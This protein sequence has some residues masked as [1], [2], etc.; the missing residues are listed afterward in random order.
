[1]R[2]ITCIPARRR[3]NSEMVRLGYVIGV[4][5]V[6]ADQLTKRW[7]EAV[8]DYARAVE[9]MP[10]FNI[11]HARNRGVSFGILNEGDAWIPWLLGVV[12]I[13]IIGVLLMWLHRAATRRLT[14]ALGLVVGGAVGNLIDRAVNFDHAV[15]DF[16]DF[17]IGTY[18]WPAFNVADSSIT[19]GVVILLIDSLIVPRKEPKLAADKEESRVRDG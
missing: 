4:T 8:L 18:H 1:M 15:I 9:I 17:Y 13:A 11:V 3:P 19:V 14:I 6:A 7:L 2:S 16:L 10:Y 5:V 12:A